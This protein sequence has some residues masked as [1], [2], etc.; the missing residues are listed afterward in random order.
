MGYHMMHYTLPVVVT[1][2]G[3]YLTRGGAV[4]TVTSVHHNRADGHYECGTPEWWSCRGG[5]VLP[6][7]L[8]DNDIVG[9]APEE[10]S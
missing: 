2:P 5:R 6:S 3:R 9:P 10:R 1:G 8:S 7:S 4:V